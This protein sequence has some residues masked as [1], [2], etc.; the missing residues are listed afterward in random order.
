MS[1]WTKG[2]P[3]SH[4]LPAPEGVTSDDARDVFHV[5]YN[6]DLELADEYGIE[7]KSMCGLWSVPDDRESIPNAGGAGRRDPRLC[8]NCTR[9]KAYRE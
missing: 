8:R 1:A 5:Y 2:V 6:A 9:T 7:V 3:N 4:T